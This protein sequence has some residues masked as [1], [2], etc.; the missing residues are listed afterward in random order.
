LPARHS[1]IQGDE[2][3]TRNPLYL[4]PRFTRGSHL[5]P[6]DLNT[7]TSDF[8]AEAPRRKPPEKETPRN[9]SAAGGSLFAEEPALNQPSALNQPLALS[10]VK[11]AAEQ[12]VSP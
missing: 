1:I 9:R 2:G 6:T 7:N 11:G 5:A 12:L 10:A 8:P 4:A 3:G